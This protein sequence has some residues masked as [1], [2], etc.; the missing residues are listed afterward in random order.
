MYS[1]SLIS[2]FDSVSDTTTDASCCVGSYADNGVV[3]TMLI[4]T[5][6]TT[7]NQIERTGTVGISR[8]LTFEGAEQHKHWMKQLK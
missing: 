3:M 6:R 5:S 8:R 7:Y 4:S 1:I 2:D